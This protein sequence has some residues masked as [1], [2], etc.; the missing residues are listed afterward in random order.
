MQ[1]LHDIIA[2]E[3]DCGEPF[4]FVHPWVCYTRLSTELDTAA[5]M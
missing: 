2:V 1:S 4:G 3:F 5:P